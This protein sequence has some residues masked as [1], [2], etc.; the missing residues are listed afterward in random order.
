MQTRYAHTNIIS[1]DWKKLADF[2]I[3]VFACKPVPPIR[4]LSGEWLA[5]GTAV[6]NAS[7]KGMH[8]RLPGHGDNGPTLEIYTYGE[9]LEK[10]EPPAANRTG[11]GHLAFEV[12]D[13][14]ELLKKMIQHGGDRLGDIVEKEIEGVGLLTFTYGTD[15]EGNIIEIQSWELY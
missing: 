4:K 13:V 6:K 15:P 10:P 1:N 11:F 7:L 14:N 3:N 2:Y 9:M 8:L 12:D 5:K